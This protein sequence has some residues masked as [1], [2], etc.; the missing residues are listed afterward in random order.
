[1]TGCGTRRHEPALLLIGTL[2]LLSLQL[3]LAG[4]AGA[5]GSYGGPSD[6]VFTSL[7]G[8]LEFSNFTFRGIRPDDVSIEVGESSITFSGDVGLS[9]WGWRKFQVGYSVRS[10][11]DQPIVG[12]QLDLDSMVDGK[13]AAVIATKKITAPHEK[14]PEPYLPLTS[15][16]DLRTKGERG[17]EDWVPPG[18]RWGGF[19]RRKFVWERHQDR[20]IGTLLAFNIASGW[21]CGCGHHHDRLSSVEDECSIE[22]D[23][24]SIEF[25]GESTLNILD[26][27]K[28]VAFGKSGAAWRSVTNT[29]EV[30][31]EPGTAALL[32]LGLIGLVG[33]GRRRR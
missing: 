3:G 21:V 24:D 20:H 10:L 4:A 9:G 30:V 17:Y 32:G 33:A 11:T 5:T 26:T 27:V 22:R 19:G 29:Y 18:D 7:D 6:E 31:P 12:T 16:E 23:S 1:M 15:F 8:T 13:G 28:L 14:N 2:A 25:D